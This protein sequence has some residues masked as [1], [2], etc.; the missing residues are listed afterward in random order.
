MIFEEFQE[1]RKILVVCPCCG[2]L[3][4]VSDLK[5]KAKGPGVKTWLDEFERKELDFDRQVEKF[6]EKEQ[7]LRETARDNGRKEAQKMINKI[8]IP[9]IKRLKLDPYDVKP[10]LHPVD[11][12]VFNGMNARDSIS[13]VMFLDR[14]TMSQTLNTLKEQIRKAVLSKKYEWKVARID[15]KCKIVYE[16]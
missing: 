10:I 11:F 13:K 9:S 7:E 12:I 16:K 8:V 6:E 3:H 1:F 2:N 5:L 15:E 4:R 14:K